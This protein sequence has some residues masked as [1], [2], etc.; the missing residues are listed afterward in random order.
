MIQ[1]AILVRDGQLELVILR[2]RKVW[3]CDHTLTKALES[4]WVSRKG[5]LSGITSLVDD[6]VKIEE[7][8]E[9]ETF[10]VEKFGVSKSERSVLLTTADN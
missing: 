10:V 1:K 3:G 6:P 2:A 9:D 7:L 5:P 4:L 8:H